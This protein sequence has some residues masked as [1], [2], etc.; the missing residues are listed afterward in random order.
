MAG[1]TISDKVFDVFPIEPLSVLIVIYR[2]NI[3]CMHICICMY[4]SNFH[5]ISVIRIITKCNNN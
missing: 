4:I 2:I 5:P 3:I 1:K